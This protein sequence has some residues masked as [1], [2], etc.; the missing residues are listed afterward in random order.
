MK[1]YKKRFRELSK[2]KENWDGYGASS[3]SPKSLEK[4]EKLLE[5]IEIVP[6]PDGTIQVGFSIDGIE[7]EIEMGEEGSS[8]L[9]TYI[10]K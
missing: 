8:L 3:I 7:I 9:S 2:L 5:S 4:A 1:E 10:T 6:T